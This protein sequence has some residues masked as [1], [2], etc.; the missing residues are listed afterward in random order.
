MHSYRNSLGLYIHVIVLLLRVRDKSNLLLSYKRKT[1][2]LLWILLYI[3]Y[4]VSLLCIF[5]L[6]YV[7]YMCVYTVCL[8]FIYKYFSLLAIQPFFVYI[9]LP[10]D[11]NVPVLNGP[12]PEG[13]Q[14]PPEESQGPTVESQGP[15]SLADSNISRHTSPPP[16][17]PLISRINCYPPAAFR[18]GHPSSN[19]CSLKL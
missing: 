19:P 2:L 12:P 16:L 5:V 11:K 13:S 6:S 10:C 17:R 18:D 14:G 1:I 9:L 8:Q 7:V 3:C 4:F 15:Q